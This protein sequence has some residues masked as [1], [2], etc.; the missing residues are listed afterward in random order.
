LWLSA[1]H[2]PRGWRLPIVA[3]WSSRVVRKRG[4]ELLID[5]RVF[6]GYQLALPANDYFGETGVG[7]T[8]LWL[9]G[10]DSA[11]SLGN[12]VLI[13]VGVQLAVAAAVRLTI[14]SGTYINPNSRV[15]CA[16]DSAI[17]RDCAI[18]WGV[19]ILDFDAHEVGIEDAFRPQA[20]PVRIGDRVWIG[21]RATVLKGVEIGDGAVVG[22]AAVVTRSVPPR[23]LVVGN[24]ARVIREDVD[25][26]NVPRDDDRSDGQHAMLDASA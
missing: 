2:Q 15:L 22:A 7:K 6:L 1:R 19:E 21:A 12:G 13:G 16:A 24:P 17:G 11:L 20:A 5:G 25:W 26:R 23:A 14:G 3:A 9:A 8:L 10:E 18:S 4:A